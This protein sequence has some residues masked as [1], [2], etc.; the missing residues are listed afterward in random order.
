MTGEE[1]DRSMRTTRD[2]SASPKARQ[3]ITQQGGK[4]FLCGE[5]LS[6]KDCT[7][8]HLIPVSKHGANTWGNVVLTHSDCNNHKSDNLPAPTAVER[9]HAMTGHNPATTKRYSVAKVFKKFGVI[10]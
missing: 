4:C 3:R 6:I 5:A 2:Y 9:F 8:D 7:K 10:E 1:E